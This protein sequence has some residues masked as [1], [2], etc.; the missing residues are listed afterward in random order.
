MSSTDLKSR[1]FRELE[2][3]DDSLLEEILGLIAIETKHE[4]VVKIPDFFK[5]D[6][7]KSI[8]QMKA[9]NIIP[10]NEVEE[11]IEKWLYK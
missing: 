6:L 4:E 1:V 9:G 3:A 8:L 5:E 7:D 10:N 2:S 11:S